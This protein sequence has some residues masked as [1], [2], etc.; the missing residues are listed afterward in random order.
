V[1]ALLA[2]DAD[3]FTAHD[4]AS[5][6]TWADRYRDANFEGSRQKTRQWHFVDIEIAPP[7]LA[8]AC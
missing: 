3:D 5:A 6:A 1:S 7:D 4:I 2:G 8:K